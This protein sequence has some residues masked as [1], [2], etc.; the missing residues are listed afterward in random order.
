MKGGAD[1]G[2]DGEEANAKSDDE[3][4]NNEV[5]IKDENKGGPV[6]SSLVDTMLAQLRNHISGN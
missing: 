3:I 1:S 5:S 4:V 2:N 6:P